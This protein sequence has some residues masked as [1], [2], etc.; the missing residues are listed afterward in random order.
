MDEVR[1]GAVVVAA[2]SGSRFGSSVP[3]QFIHL[4]GIPLV[5]WSIEAFLNDSEIAETVVVTPA[6]RNSWTRCWTPPV[7]VRT[8]SGGE[9]RQDSV[10]AGLRSLESCTHV[11]VHDAARPLLNRDL[12]RRVMKASLKTGAAVPV[13]PVRDTVK[14]TTSRGWVA[15]TVPRSRLVLSQTPQGF[16]LKKLISVLETSDDVTDEAQAMEAAGVKVATVPGE[17]WNIKL[18]DPG[19]LE[20]LRAFTGRK[21]EVRTAVGIDFHPFRKNTQL[22]LGGCLIESDVGLSGHSDGDAVMHAVAD[23]VLS[24]SRLGDI[25][26]HF[27]PGKE[28]WKDVDSA[29]ILRESMRMARS[30]NWRLRQLDVTVIAPFPRIAPVRSR[31]IKRIAEILDVDEDRIWVKGTTT[32]TLGDIGSGKGLACFAQVV[33]ERPETSAGM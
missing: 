4:R 3:K 18:T 2:G 33:M 9:R 1:W 6:D 30:E 20:T 15:S 32:N 24:V 10:K 21:M 23:A 28:E 7:G 16:L 11:L 19:D 13:L 22:K 25:G 27:P 12:V 31:M 29:H 26:V 8:V 5:E 14:K 17:R